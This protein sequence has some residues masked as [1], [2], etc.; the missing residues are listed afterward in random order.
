MDIINNQDS[1]RQEREQPGN[2]NRSW[3]AFPGVVLFTWFTLISQLW[4]LF[5]P[6]LNSWWN[7]LHPRGWNPLVAR[8]LWGHDI[9]LGP[10][11]VLNKKCLSS[12]SSRCLGLWFWDRRKNTCNIERNK[13][14]EIIGVQQ[15][16]KENGLWN[17]WVQILTLP[18]ANYVT[19]SKHLSSLRLSFSIHKR[20]PTISGL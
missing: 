11:T 10:K 7:Q 1:G 4:G 19:L 12:Q 16:S 15:S 17:S 3:W 18:H 8:W 9:F 2:L 6:F 20:T 5:W 13:N 14:S